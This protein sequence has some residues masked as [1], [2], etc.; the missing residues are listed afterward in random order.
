M[1]GCPSQSTGNPRSWAV[2]VSV[3][4]ALVIGSILLSKGGV[5]AVKL[6][7]DGVADGSDLSN[8]GGGLGGALGCVFGRKS[9]LREQL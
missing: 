3:V 5:A 8:L 4:L 1:R 9:G 2:L 6:Q 7:C